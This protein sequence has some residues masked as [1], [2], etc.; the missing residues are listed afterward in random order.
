MCIALRYNYDSIIPTMPPTVER[1]GR[2]HARSQRAFDGRRTEIITRHYDTRLG[3]SGLLAVAPAPM[4]ASVPP[5][6]FVVALLHTSA[7][8][9]PP[10][11]VDRNGVA[12]CSE[13]QQAGALAYRQAELQ[14]S[15]LV[16]ASVCQLLAVVAVH[17]HG[18]L[19]PLMHHVH[20]ERLFA[21]WQ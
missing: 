12:S 9:I 3:A 2:P 15:H 4:C 19:A 18:L 7:H 11:R 6:L 1:F 8:A 20:G 14:R 21:S 10:D 13:L 5:C 17:T 16:P